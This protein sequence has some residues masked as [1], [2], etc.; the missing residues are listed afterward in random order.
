MGNPIN[1]TLGALRKAGR[2][3]DLS[4]RKSAQFR[5]AACELVLLRDEVA[6]GT[7][8]VVADPELERRSFDMK[9]AAA[10]HRTLEVDMQIPHRRSLKSSVN[11]AKKSRDISDEGFASMIKTVEVGNSARHKSC[12][13]LIGKRR[14]FVLVKIPVVLM[15]ILKQPG[16]TTV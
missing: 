5:R 3:A 2:L 10:L 4:C 16:S 9:R 8:S 1:F 13:L 15:E 12:A 7:C 6:A 11:D 14:L